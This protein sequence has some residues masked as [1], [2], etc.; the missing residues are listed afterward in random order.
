MTTAQDRHQLT[1]ATSLEI[2]H[3]LLQRLTHNFLGVQFGVMPV[4]PV[5]PGH[6]YAFRILLDLVPVRF[7][8]HLQAYRSVRSRHRLIKHGTYVSSRLAGLLHL[9][10]SVIPDVLVRSHSCRY[11]IFAR[12]SQTD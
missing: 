4:D 9:P 7:V 2:S 12:F 10:H 5:F 6:L 3:E 11:V 8:P 1:K